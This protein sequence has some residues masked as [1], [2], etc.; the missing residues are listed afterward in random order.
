MVQRTLV[1]LDKRGMLDTAVTG[2]PF[3]HDVGH[4]DLHYNLSLLFQYGDTRMH[5]SIACVPLRSF[6]NIHY[7]IN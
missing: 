1:V 2:T 6:F 3:R 7:K 5:H 4:A